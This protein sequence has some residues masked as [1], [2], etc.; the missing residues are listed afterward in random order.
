M[1]ANSQ[2]QEVTPSRPSSQMSANNQS[3]E[4]T[5]SR[6][7]TLHVNSSELSANNQSQEVTPSCPWPLHVNSSEMSANSQSKEVTPSHPIQVIT[8]GH[9]RPVGNL[10]VAPPIYSGN[11][12]SV[13]AYADAPELLDNGTG[14]SSTEITMIY[15]QSHSR[16]NFSSKLV[17]RLFDEQTRK[18][19]NVAGKVGKA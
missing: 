10:H 15:R 7:W 11:T 8:L 4:V 16:R 2:N 18:T 6:L 3:Q 17:S 5:P 13:S 14:L 9:P 1:S 12:T 19:S